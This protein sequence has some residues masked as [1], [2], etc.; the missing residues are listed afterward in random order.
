MSVRT[1]ADEKLESAREHLKQ[2]YKDLWF[3][4]D[5]DAWGVSE[6]NNEYVEKFISLAFEIKQLRTKLG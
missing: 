5:E 4:T 6:Y 1:T 2:A 3:F